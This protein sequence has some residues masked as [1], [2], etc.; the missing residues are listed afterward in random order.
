MHQSDVTP[1]TQNKVLLGNRDCNVT[2]Q[3]PYRVKAI[4]CWR[5]QGGLHKIIRSTLGV[6]RQSKSKSLALITS[7]CLEKWQLYS[8]TYQANHLVRLYIV[9]NGHVRW[10]RAA[11][12]TLIEYPHV[13]GGKTYL[14]CTKR[15]YDESSGV[16]V[17]SV[18]HVMSS[19]MALVGDTSRCETRSK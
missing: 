14:R 4:R 19:R 16:T 15:G 6:S 17:S 11:Q 3:S 8:R 12:P 1:Y 18:L 7:I 2:S 13:I 9:C 5:T 10:K